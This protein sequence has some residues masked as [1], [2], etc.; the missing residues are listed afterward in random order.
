[1]SLKLG[2]VVERIG[3]T[4]LAGVDQAHKNVT[5]VGTVGG[6]VEERVLAV[7]NGLLQG[8]FTDV[9]VQRRPGARAETAS[10]SPSA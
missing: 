7:Q 5:D 4:E 1:V 10:A 8:A 6:L 3:P 9:I 2:H